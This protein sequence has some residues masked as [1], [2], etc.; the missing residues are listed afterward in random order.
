M[1]TISRDKVYDRLDK[2]IPPSAICESGET[3]IFET[4]DCYDDSVTSEERPL[5][6]REDALG[7]PA[8][9]PLYICL[10]Y[11]SIPRDTMD[12]V[13]L[14][15]PVKEDISN[16]QHAN[17]ELINRLLDLE[18]EVRYLKRTEEK[19]CEEEK[20]AYR[21]VCRQKERCHEKIKCCQKGQEGCPVSCGEKQTEN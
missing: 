8:T 13:N 15:D 20:C 21:E 1:L 12:Q 14:P 3:V 2:N 16:L 18:A 10:L 5:G 6:D 11:T 17:S 9:G 7:N 19:S 4:R